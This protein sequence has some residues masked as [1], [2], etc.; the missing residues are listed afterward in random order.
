MK[1]FKTFAAAIA[2]FSIL[3]ATS[4]SSD[5]D[6]TPEDD[7]GGNVELTDLSGNLESS[8][9]LLA[10]EEYTVTGPYLV[11]AGAT[12][13]IPAG[14]VIV[15]QSTQ[16]RYIAVE[17]GG[18]IDIQGT[19][20]LPV[21]MRSD[22]GASGS[23][24]GLLICGEAPT[25]EGVDV[26]AEV[27][28]LIYGGT[29]PAHSSGNIDYLIIEDAGAQI[30]SESQYNG[31]TLYSVGSGTTIDNVAI[32]NGADDGVEF[33]GGTVS[34]TNLYLENNED[35]AVDWTEGWNG[36][37]TNTYSLHTIEGFSTAVEADGDNGNPKL[38]N[39]T[40]VSNTGGTALQFKKESGATMT[41]VFLNGYTTNVD[42]KDNGPIGNVIIDGAPM[43]DPSNDVFNGTAV[44]ISGWDW[45]NS[46]I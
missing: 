2:A 38:I 45:I 35:D 23:W 40:A 37:I 44:D 6:F 7:G 43:T 20:N 33:F 28:G 3:F 5:D 15:S 16:D 9:V 4:C 8:R 27:A 25:T 18:R 14:T 31:L 41:N 34:V 1:H 42:M 10:T 46:N 39:F 22:S 29:N 21:I 30:N 36:T 13:T 12:L 11:K 19:A 24:G 32:I 26:T 17:Q